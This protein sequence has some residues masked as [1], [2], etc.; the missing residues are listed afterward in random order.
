MFKGILKRF[1]SKVLYFSL[2]ITER[3][4]D[5]TGENNPPEPYKLKLNNTFIKDK[6]TILIP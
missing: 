5:K 6:R 3:K 1:I 2:R 4:N